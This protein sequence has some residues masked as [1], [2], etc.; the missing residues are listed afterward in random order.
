MLKFGWKV[1]HK[2]KIS[3]YLE[4]FR[5][6]WCP[7]DPQVARLVD[8]Y[9]G[10]HFILKF[11]KNSTLYIFFYDFQS[12]PWSIFTS[13]MAI[14]QAFLLII[15]LN[16]TNSKLLQPFI[17]W[18]ARF[19]WS[20]TPVLIHYWDGQHIKPGQFQIGGVLET[21]KCTDGRIKT[22]TLRTPTTPN[23]RQCLLNEKDFDRLTCVH[24]CVLQQ[25]LK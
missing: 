11:D 10:F 22:L 4:E 2:T 9:Q 1:A 23:I 14:F 13:L 17:S 6:F 8:I 19:W 16:N 21:N 5:F 7:I 3:Q 25:D 24:S 12:N 18:F 15:R 20:R